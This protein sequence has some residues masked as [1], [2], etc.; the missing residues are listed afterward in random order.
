M[1]V[2]CSLELL[3]VDH[4]Q[5]ILNLILYQTNLNSALFL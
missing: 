4:W 5:M 1:S 2:Y 3:D